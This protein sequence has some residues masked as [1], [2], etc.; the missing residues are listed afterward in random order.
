MTAQARLPL[1][2]GEQLGTSRRSLARLSALKLHLA[3]WVKTCA[4]YHQAAALYEEL[5]GLSD[6]ELHRRGLSRS[7]LAWD[8]IQACDRTNGRSLPDG[9][10]TLD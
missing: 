9:R 2:I 4:D 10:F 5:H 6:A 8:L 3:A 7:T 1:V